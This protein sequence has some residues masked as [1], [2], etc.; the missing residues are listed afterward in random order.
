MVNAA[1]L[2]SSIGDPRGTLAR[3]LLTISYSNHFDDLH[4]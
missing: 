2:K 3:T 1:D 4:D